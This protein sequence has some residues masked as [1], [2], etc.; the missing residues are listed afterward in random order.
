MKL[1]FARHLTIDEMTTHFVSADATT[2]PSSI[3]HRPFKRKKCTLTDI[4]KYKRDSH[5][6]TRR[7]FVASAILS[8]RPLSTLWNNESS[9]IRHKALNNSSSPPSQ[10]GLRHSKFSLAVVM[11]NTNMYHR[12]ATTSWEYAVNSSAQSYSCC[13]PSLER[14]PLI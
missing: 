12:P 7:P 5:G 3:C 1:A 8:K 2:R 11:F 6:G 9:T 4:M 13:S 10:Y 14:R